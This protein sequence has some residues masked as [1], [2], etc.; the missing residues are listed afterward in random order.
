MEQGIVHTAAT[1]LTLDGKSFRCPT[2]PSASSAAP[3]TSEHPTGAI[4]VG[5]RLN[6]DAVGLR[7]ASC[8]LPVT[9]AEADSGQVIYSL[10][11]LWHRAHF[12]CT[13]CNVEIGTDG[14]DFRECPGATGRPMC[15]DCYMETRHPKC[16][17]CAKPLMETFVRVGQHRWHRSCV[18]CERCKN[19]F[20]FN[21]YILHD[22]KMYDFDCFHMKKL[23]PFAVAGLGTETNDTS[24][25]ITS[26]DGSTV[27]TVITKPDLVP[28]QKKPEMTPEVRKPDA[29]SGRERA[30]T[31]LSR[32]SLTTLSS[33]DSTQ[34]LSGATGGKITIPALPNLAKK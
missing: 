15:L 7:C 3:T 12:S 19:P 11:R 18:V 21:E 8:R 28:A 22:G 10:R 2:V 14:R 32:S 9:E 25:T 34:P 30:N 20:P 31:P 26:S 27:S 5:R 33:M 1:T 6:S 23:E 17:S 16:F 24:S 13:R 29:E 4:N